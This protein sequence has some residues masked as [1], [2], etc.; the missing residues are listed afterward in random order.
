MKAIE[1]VE[2]MKRIFISIAC[3]VL[4]AGCGASE[5]GSSKGTVLDASMNTVMV[6]DAA[7]DTLTFSTVDAD[8]SGLDGLL[9]G[10]A[11]EVSYEGEYV[12]GMPA[13]KLSSAE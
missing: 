10:D 8:K 12:P 7:G 11:V 2:V 5:T 3:C 6:V 13:V 4:L 1:S 9:I